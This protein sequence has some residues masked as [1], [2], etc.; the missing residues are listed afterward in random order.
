MAWPLRV[1]TGRDPAKADEP[2]HE[3]HPRLRACEGKDQGGCPRRKTKDADFAA[4][5]DPPEAIGTLD[6]LARA[7]RFWTLD[8]SSQLA[9]I[10]Q[11]SGF[12]T[13]TR[14]QV[15]EALG[16]VDQREIDMFEGLFGTR[17][18]ERFP[19]RKDHT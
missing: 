15:N 5:S 11:P 3:G 19:T 6:L 16:A 7:Y 9:T 4:A 14:V 1:H 18:P 13:V 8:D 12:S 10:L 2:S 17:R